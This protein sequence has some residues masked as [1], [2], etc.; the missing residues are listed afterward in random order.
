MVGGFSLNKRTLLLALLSVA[1]VSAS[2]SIAFADYHTS[3]VYNVFNDVTLRFEEL[4]D[5][6]TDFYAEIGMKLTFNDTTESPHADVIFNASV[7]N[8]RIIVQYYDDGS[9]TGAVVYQTGD[10]VA[11]IATF[12]W[13]DNDNYT[14]YVDLDDGLLTVKHGLDSEGYSDAV[15]IVDEFSINFNMTYVGEQGVVYCAT[16][17]FIQVDISTYGGSGGSY[18]GAISA[19]LPTIVQFAMLG[20]VMGLVKKFR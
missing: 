9:E 19:W 2:V 13:V 8:K 10:D 12:D 18:M 4:D 16:A 7:L 5:T 15:L 6:Y 14:T 1:L 17:G 3:F 11:Q 20:M